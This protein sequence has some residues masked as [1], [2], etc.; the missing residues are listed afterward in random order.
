MTI[1]LLKNGNEIGPLELSEVQVLL[2]SD[3][4]SRSQAVRLEDGAQ[5]TVGS[6]DGIRPPKPAVSVAPSGQAQGAA[7]PP[8]ASLSRDVKSLKRN[9]AAAT[10]ELSQFMSEMRGKSPG[11]MLGAI[12]QNSLVRSGVTAA[13]ILL[14]ILFITTIIPFAVKDDTIVQK[15]TSPPPVSAETP[16]HTP[17]QTPASASTNSPTA[18]PL[19]EKQKVADK[20]GIGEARQG[21]PSEPN[22]FETTGDLLQELE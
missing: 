20:L 16:L 1:Y 18:L 17:P 9:S 13:L 11:D 15:E 12:V 2:D 21:Q 3:C 19:G 8:M 22:P 5:T 10:T 7:P 4:I 14:A 6:L